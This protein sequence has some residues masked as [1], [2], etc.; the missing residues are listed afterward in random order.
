MCHAERT[1]IDGWLRAA[2]GSVDGAE[3]VRRKVMAASRR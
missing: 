3:E 2:G 1:E